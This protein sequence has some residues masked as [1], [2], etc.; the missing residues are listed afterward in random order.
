MPT[1]FGQP[2]K[3]NDLAGEVPIGPTSE[4]ADSKAVSVDRATERGTTMSHHTPQV[5]RETEQYRSPRLRIGGGHARKPC[6]NQCL[7]QSSAPGGIPPYGG[8]IRADPVGRRREN[9]PL[10]PRPNPVPRAIIAPETAPEIS[11]PKATLLGSETLSIGRGNGPG[12]R[13][14]LHPDRCIES[15]AH[16]GVPG[17]GKGR[18][19]PHHD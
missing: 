2:A 11:L 17:S 18:F 15:L 13:A 8:R 14:K 4:N 3:S 12:C 9:S 1:P 10:P 5:Q 19:P 7:N 6:S 16:T